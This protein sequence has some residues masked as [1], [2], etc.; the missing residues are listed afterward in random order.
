MQVMRIGIAV[1]GVVVFTRDGVGNWRER[2][3]SI[4]RGQI[5]EIGERDLVIAVEDLRVIG[6]H[7]ARLG[8]VAPP[9]QKGRRLWGS[10]DSGPRTT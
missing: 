1:E 9:P 10:A 2:L 7:H 8:C 3:E 5:P 4:R 6:V